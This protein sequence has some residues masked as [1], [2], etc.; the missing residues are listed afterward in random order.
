M[1][2]TNKDLTG[3]DIYITKF[4]D[5]KWTNPEIMQSEINS[6]GNLQ[7]SVCL[8]P[9][10]TVLYFSSNR[11]GG[12]GGLDLYLVRKLPNGSWGPP[13]NLGLTINTSYDEDSPFIHPD[14]K[15]L[16]FSSRGHENMGEFDI[17]KSELLD[18]DQLWW[19]APENLG[20]P[21][22]TVGDD[23]YFVVSADAKHGYF[24]SNRPEGFSNADI[25]FVTMELALENRVLL[26]GTVSTNEPVFKTLKATIIIIDNEKNE[27][28]GIYRT[29]IKTGKYLLVL[30][31]GKK[32]K[33]TVEAEGYH[34]NISEIDLTKRAVL[35]DLNKHINLEPIISSKIDVI[36]IEKDS[37][38][39]VRLDSIQRLS[40]DSI[41]I[42][43]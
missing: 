33:M 23:I 40:P 3:G 12:Y 2:R 9:D 39:K 21:I 27:L 28:Q 36:K 24:S 20:Y 1:Y 11:P 37:I 26:K 32:Y 4:I 16:Y 43:H 22:N 7:P 17:F 35:S 29:N 41:K 8:S 30:I 18:E 25:Y 31:P 42:N 5:G 19:S 14:G 38:E 6:P 34:S 15:I 10:E 13:T